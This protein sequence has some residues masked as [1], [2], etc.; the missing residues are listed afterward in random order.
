MKGF[1][2][3]EPIKIPQDV[4]IEDR[5]I[6]TITLRQIIMLALSGGVS[7]AIYA[8]FEKTYG[9]VS[10]PLIVIAAIPTVIIGI[11]AFVRVNNVSFL[12]FTFLLLERLLK[13]TKRHFG[14]RRGITQNLTRTSKKEGIP[15][16]K[17]QPAK[18]EN[19]SRLGTILD[20][21]P[22]SSHNDQ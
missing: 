17:K 14:P 4:S 22:K 6:G 12:R 5:I 20:T 10:L 16:E 13:P 8:Y 9:L 11:F 3:F 15:K 7:Y 2:A 1:M 19:L 18:Q 21:L